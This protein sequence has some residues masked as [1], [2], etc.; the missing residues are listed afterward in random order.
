MKLHRLRLENFR[1]VTAR[2]VEFPDSGVVVLTGRNEIGKTSMIDALDALIEL[3]DSSR[4]KKI[5]EAKPAGRDVP[6]LVEAEFS[7]GPTRVV[8]T[9]QWLKRPSTT[10]RHVG[11]EGRTL[12]GREAHDA[13]EQLWAG[14]D[15]ALWKAL[16]FMQAGGLT[17]NALTDSAAL[18]RALECH[19]GQAQGDDREVASLL[20]RVRAECDKYWTSTRKKNAR[21][22]QAETDCRAA[23]AA[24]AETAEELRGITVVEE[25]LAE[26]T[27]EIAATGRKLGTARA[28]KTELDRAA[29]EIEA[30]QR[31]RQEAQRRRDAARA[32]LDRARERSARRA[33]LV[34]ALAADEERS[35]AL[36]GELLACEQ[37]LAPVHEHAEAAEE[38]RAAAQ[39][40]VQEARAAH[41]SAR[42]DREHLDDV[43]RHRRT[44]EI[45]DSLEA[46]RAQLAELGSRP[47]TE[48]DE[49]IVDE[50]ER[51]ERAAETAEAELAAGSARVELTAL[52]RA[53]PIVRGGGTEEVGPEEPWSVPVTDEVEVEIPGEW[54]V[55]VLP[56]QGI[57]TRRDAARTARERCTALLARHGVGSVAEARAQWRAAQELAQQVREAAAQRD[58]LLGG[59]DE[60]RLRDDRDRLAAAIEQYGGRRDDE[61]PL[62]A[63]A[64]AAQEAV[65]A[66]EAALTE[67]EDAVHRAEA[68]A[69]AA[70]SALQ[71]AQAT[72]HSLQGAALEQ[73]RALTAGRARLE[74]A[75]REVPDEDLD[76]AA[77][78]AAEALA[79][80][81]E[82]IEAHEAALAGLDADRVL[83]DRQH[84]ADEIEGLETLLAER[85]SRHNSLQGRLEGMGRDRVQLA[86]DQAGTRLEAARRHLAGVERRAEAAL[87]LERTLLEH[88]ERAHA[89]YVQPFRT[90]VEQLGRAVYGP[91]FEVLVS[92]SLEVEQ[93]KLHGD[94]LP[95]A[96]LST[97]AKEQLV[98]L[99]RLATALLVDPED[100]VPV[101]LDD[102]L[103]HSDP[104]R[105]R[106]LAS[107]ITTAG[108]RTQVIV[109]TSNPERFVNLR[110]AHRIEM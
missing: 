88:R 43:E 20:E 38:R 42:E 49:E 8:Y 48:I 100:G 74:D 61:V 75:R 25:E 47:G 107:A 56:E 45:L 65:E 60:S 109:L 17:Q 101:L 83:G 44:A 28:E 4:H 95:F 82:E 71:S 15:T 73:E 103:G 104:Q 99:I 34:A 97:G 37:E 92:G 7:I 10:L 31:Q 21:F 84:V 3:P 79:T 35:T 90:E 62:P 19:A 102:A 22:V 70:R 5:A 36:A 91:D 94:W 55:R 40:A 6:V 81:Q 89:Q 33:E 29:G 106:R 67:A 53:R 13:A 57:E 63:S 66:A 77:A 18:R 30:V 52:G 85:R 72:L 96:A 39:A 86:H 26:L 110:E 64:A 50:L 51:A 32:E 23:E 59:E 14:A 12:T 41:R 9:K 87:L 2:E 78:A 80:V 16:R 76:R 69:E 98:I 58:L 108:E 46:V 24:A 1:G 105:L 11:G 93:R 68:A 27:E 54:R